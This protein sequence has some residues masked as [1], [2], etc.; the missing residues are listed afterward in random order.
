MYTS[1]I[2]HSGLDTDKKVIRID[3]KNVSVYSRMPKKFDNLE[4]VG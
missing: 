3:N 1:K 4:A 2:V